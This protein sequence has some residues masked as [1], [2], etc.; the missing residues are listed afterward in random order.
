VVEAAA[1]R[2]ARGEVKRRAVL[3]S[4]SAVLDY[5]RAAMAFA[6]KEQFRILLGMRIIGEH[7]SSRYAS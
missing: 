4:W 1:H 6:D 2:L 5:C 3:G 7:S